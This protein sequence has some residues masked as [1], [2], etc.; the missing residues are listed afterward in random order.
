MRISQRTLQNI[1]RFLWPTLL[2]LIQL[3][4]GWGSQAHVFS[5][6]GRLRRT[7]LLS[8]T[9][10]TSLGVGGG[11]TRGSNKLSPREPSDGSIFRWRL[12]TPT[13]MC[14]WS[15]SWVRGGKNSR[16]RDLRQVTPI[17]RNASSPIW[18]EASLHS[19]RF[20][21]AVWTKRCQTVRKMMSQEALAGTPTLTAPLGNPPNFSE[22]LFPNLYTVATHLWQRCFARCKLN[23][24][25]LIWGP[26]AARPPS[27]ELPFT[28]LNHK[29]VALYCSC[30]F[31]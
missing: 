6:H 9:R 11:A 10:S 24:L 30:H 2:C 18:L 29:E 22:T 5:W 31:C 16:L 1:E 7:H 28:G 17:K 4:L 19:P 20:R 27:M 23:F 25:P 8:G 26:A 14:S 21:A 12:R 3:V 15:F 13:R